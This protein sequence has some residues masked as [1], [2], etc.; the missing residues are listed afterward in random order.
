[1]ID[2]ILSSAIVGI[3]C[4]LLAILIQYMNVHR[5]WNRVWF[6]Y[7]CIGITTI[8]LYVTMIAAITTTTIK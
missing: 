7:A 1:M 3:S 5:L 2:L 4:G 6:I 8:I